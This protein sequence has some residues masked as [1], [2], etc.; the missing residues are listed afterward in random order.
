MAAGQQQPGEQPDHRAEDDHRRRHCQHLRPF[1]RRHLGARGE[2]PALQV[3]AADQQQQRAQQPARHQLE[4]PGQQEGH[5]SCRQRDADHR[6]R[7]MPADA[8]DQH[9][10]VHG[11]GG[12]EA[13][14]RARSRGRLGG[15][16]QLAVDIGVALR[17]RLHRADV[18]H[19]PKRG[20][21]HQHRQI[22]E[23]LR[24]Y[25]PVGRRQRRG[26]PE[27]R[28]RQP[29]RQV[30]QPG[31]GALHGDVGADQPGDHMVQ[32]DAADDHHRQDVG[33]LEALLRDQ[34]R[35]AAGDGG[36]EMR[37]PGEV[38]DIRDVQH[39]ARHPQ[40][41]G[42]RQPSG[43]GQEAGDD[44]KGQEAHQ[45]AEAAIAEHAEGQRGCQRD[46]EQR[47][48]RGRRQ[49][50]LVLEL[51]AQRGEAGRQ[52]RRRRPLR[53]RHLGLQPA[54]QAEDRAAHRGAEQQAAETGGVG[55]I[56]PALEDQRGIRHDEG[57]VEQAEHGDRRQGLPPGARSRKRP[58]P[59]HRPR[60]PG[61][62]REP[63]PQLTEA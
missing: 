15:D 61:P 10:A 55:R 51:A 3:V 1:D 38:A 60:P 48:R 35:R 50:S 36:A 34:Q 6:R 7:A 13:A 27:R 14:E 24:Q 18:H 33:A 29:V 47:H 4:Q 17:C 59:M 5:Q 37:Q 57:D 20:H 16:P 46:E 21:Q 41:A 54:T 25:A 30:G 45:P 39:A 19:Q 11:Q 43:C 49:R 26:I 42:Q 56:E 62:L 53:R 63:R 12:E 44:R 9:G 23:M 58:H 32:Q 8:A 22:D 2:R 28:R 40:P 52:D 31:G